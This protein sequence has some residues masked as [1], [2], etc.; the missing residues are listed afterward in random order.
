MGHGS[1]SSTWMA[2][3]KTPIGAIFGAAIAIILLALYGYGTLFLINTVLACAGKDPCQAPAN[4]TG[5]VYVVTT[6]GGLVSALVVAQLAVTEPGKSPSI[7]T[8][9]PT[10][11]QAI[12]ATNVVVLAYLV[13]W[14]AIGLAALVIGVMRY[15]DVNSTLADQGRTWLGLAVSA[16]YAYF[17]IK[18]NQ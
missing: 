8:F 12:T 7:G 18:P 15:P 13:I 11:R 9:V 3:M 6:V 10:T 2:A 14:I 17:G 5:V 4:T 16:A 1:A